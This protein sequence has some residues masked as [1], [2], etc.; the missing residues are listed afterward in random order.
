VDFL[1]FCC[2]IVVAKNG[3]EK[4]K[5]ENGASHFSDCQRFSQNCGKTADKKQQKYYS[6]A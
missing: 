2:A 5:V 1:L 3:L 6:A 4:S